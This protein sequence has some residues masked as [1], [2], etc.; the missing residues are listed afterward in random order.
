MAKTENIIDGAE[1]RRV[2]EA[3]EV[4]KS[5]ETRKKY[6]ALGENWKTGQEFTPPPGWENAQFHF[7]GGRPPGAGFGDSQAGFSDFFE[8]LFGGDFQDDPSMFRA[9]GGRRAPRARRG[10]D[11]EAEITV[12]LEDCHRGLHT[13]I[14][15]QTAE[16]DESGQIRRGTKSYTVD[17]PR[18]VTAGSRIR[19]AGQGGQGQ[20]GGPAGDLFL[21]IRVKPHSVFKIDGHDLTLVLPI[22]PW[23]AALGARVPVPTLDGSASLAVPAS[24][25]SGQRLRLRG[26]GLAKRKDDEAGDL[27]VDI[28]IRVP[29]KLSDQERALFEKLAET[30]HYNPRTNGRS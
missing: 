6:D 28:Q 9:T 16:L 3:Y 1:L 17:I 23:E 24:T 29:A 10:T 22:S 21:R 2:A 5:P 8:T 26:K 30:S 11:H 14:S 15:L 18:G 12:S 20:G 27:Y 4:L 19:L 7:S 25:Q 13:T